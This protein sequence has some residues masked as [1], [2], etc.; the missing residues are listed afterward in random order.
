M[1]FGIKFDKCPS[2]ISSDFEL[3]IKAGARTKTSAAADLPLGSLS[4]RLYPRFS[5]RA[6]WRPAWR[7]TTQM[8]TATIPKKL[9]GVLA[10][11]L[12]FLAASS[13]KAGEHWSKEKAEEW[14]RGQPWLVGCNYVP[15]TAV[16]QLE[17]WGWAEGLGFNSVRVFL[18]NIPFEHDGD[19]FLRRID[20]F[21]AIAAKHKI[22]VMLVLFDAVWDP[23]PV[24]GKQRAP[25]PGLHNS[26]W[27]QSPGR[28]ILKDP[29]RRDALESYVKGV[30]G[31]FRDDRRVQVWDLFNEPDNTNGSSYGKEE[32][33]DK[34]SLCL[35]LLRKEF[36][37]VRSVGPSQPLTSGVWIGDW[38]AEKLSPM[39]R[40]QLEE[41]DVISFHDYSNLETLKKRI[42]SLRRY[43]R[44]ILC[45][46]YMARPA[47]STFEPNLG[48]LRASKVG[49]YNWGFVDGKS[50]TIYPWDSWKKPYDA[51]PPVWFHDIFRKNGAPYDPKEVAYIRK[52]TDKGG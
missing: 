33:A 11:A 23:N 16:N 37:W 22:G 18:H 43:G 36:V 45:T 4:P 1:R 3:W 10:A 20:D 26:G 38:E 6:G 39:A 35:E 49:A 15:S 41:S 19:G 24:P 8:T 34:A 48:A 40:L 30:V 21:L 2:L 5:A 32:P 13:A 25:K 12:V 52:I 9:V 42:E 29:K 27:V 7:E 31:R 14:G 51:E 44:P 50:Q 17:M 47:G 28:D 46:E